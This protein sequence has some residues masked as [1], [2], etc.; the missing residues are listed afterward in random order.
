M[1]D[2]ITWLFKMAEGIENCLW[3]EEKEVNLIT[4]WSEKPCVFDVTSSGY[5]NRFKK[6]ATIFFSLLSR[7]SERFL[8]RFGCKIIT[9]ANNF[10][11]FAVAIFFGYIGWRNFKTSPWSS[12]LSRSTKKSLGVS[13]AIFTGDQIRCG[14]GIKSPG[15]SPA[16]RN[17]PLKEKPKRPWDASVTIQSKKNLKMQELVT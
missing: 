10:F 1:G 12:T 2:I 3:T 14:R 17:I 5:I 9:A 11:R 6:D 8:E 13:A 4:L 7:F 16:Q 15:V